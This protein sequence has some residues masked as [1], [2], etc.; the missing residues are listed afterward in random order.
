AGC[1]VTWWTSASTSVVGSHVSPPSC[2]RGMPPTWTFTCTVPSGA[3]AIVRVSGGP[4]HG[5][6]HPSRPWISSNELTGPPLRHR[7]AS[8]PPTNRPRDV[9][10]R[11]R[12]DCHSKL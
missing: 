11:Q 7:R 3:S 2:E 12:G 9:G 5:V 1:V 4:P 10:S 6:Y 8:A